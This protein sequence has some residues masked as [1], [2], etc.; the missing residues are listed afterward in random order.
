[1]S[2]VVSAVCLPLLLRFCLSSVLCCCAAALLVCEEIHLVGDL[3]GITVCRESHI[4]NLRLHS[5]SFFSFFVSFCL[6]CLFQ[7]SHFA[8]ALRC[9]VVA[10]C[11]A[12]NEMAEVLQEFPELT[13]KVEGKEVPIMQRTCLVANTSNM[14]VAARE[15]S[16]YT[17]T[18]TP[19][20]LCFVLCLM[21]SRLFS[22]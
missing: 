21:C 3:T 22:S 4:L 10:L 15:A 18:D 7:S 8:R 2:V 11:F 13:T 14:P 5:F 16:I 9:G 17:G 6:V 19:L 12:G 1:M 20:S